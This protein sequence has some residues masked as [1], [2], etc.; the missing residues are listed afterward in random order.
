MPNIKLRWLGPVLFLLGIGAFASGCSK[1]V[2][3]PPPPAK[4]PETEL[5]YAP[6]ELDT[7]TFRVHFFWNGYDD[8]GEV[9]RFRYAVDADTAVDVHQ[10]KTTT[11]KDTVLLFQVDPVKEIRVHVFKV[12]SEDNA[13]NVDP[14][15]ARRAFSAKTLP[16]T[17]KI[18][19]G[20]AAFGVVVGPNFTFEWSGIDPD[21]GET[22]GKV[23]IDSFQYQLLLVGAIADE[24]VPP[25]SWHQPLPSFDPDQYVLLL[26]AAVDDSLP[27]PY[28]DWKWKGVRGLKKRYRNA[29]PGEYY[30]AVR[31]VDVAGA[32]EKDIAFVRNIRHFN[33]TNRNP[34]PALSVWSNVLN[35]P[36]DIASGP[37]DYPR[38]QIQIF[39]GETISFAWVANADSYGGEI[40]GYTYAL[41]DT[42]SFPGLDPR[43][44]GATFQ[45]AVLPPG[46][47]FLYVRA[48]DDGGLITNM[49]IPLLIVHPA[50]KDPGVQR[51]I[52]FVDDSTGPGNALTRIFSFPSD[53]EETDW[54]TLSQGGQGPLFS[55]G[56]PF[57]EWD[58]FR[59]SDGSE[60]RRQP[61]PRDMATFTTVVWTTDFNNGGS[62][63]TALFK[64]IAGGNYSELQGYLRA[65]GTLIVTGWSLVK[66][67]CSPLNLAY[68]NVVPSGICAAYVPESRGYNG[69]VFPRMFM[70]VDAAKPNL[71]ARRVLGARDFVSAIPTAAGTALGYAIAEID[72]GS[73]TSGAKWNTNPSPFG[74]PDEN[75][76][77]GLGGNG[78]I[79]GWVMA[80]NFGCQEDQAVFGIEPGSAPIARAIYSYHGVPKGVLMNGGPSPREG[81]ACGVVMQSHDLGNGSGIYNP[82]AAVGRIVLLG[83]P[84]YFVK[85]QQ[86]IDIM[87]T[88]FAYV[89]ASPTLP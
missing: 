65:G 8:D 60:G 78:A 46:N 42:S 67:T 24:T 41:D 39:E 25:P 80:R 12:A 10:W 88:A 27:S 77:P 82:K 9:A 79:E 47:H 23:P 32:T 55:L 28:G 70:G 53:G 1:V 37:E 76:A 30:F 22:G 36:L 52:L 58:T 29:T 48:V 43:T 84:L 45:P 19:R 72:T 2:V 40:V 3:P 38:K 16:P 18:E 66:D 49:K 51:S 86:A 75:L 21:G 62:I 33:V 74:N 44:L 89:N 81:Y 54:W 73:A 26:R 20:P 35:R 57:T 14:T 85:D 87:R 7:T 31:A 71:D 59:L 68:V 15:P 13:G 83:F 6:V 61:E 4:M 5:T 64:T 50:F 11:A 17:S 63:Q 34:G 69:T 56:V